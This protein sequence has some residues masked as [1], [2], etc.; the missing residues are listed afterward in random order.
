M[1]IMGQSFS[2]LR[3]WWSG[4]KVYALLGVGVA[5]IQLH[6]LGSSPTQA[7][8]LSKHI[9]MRNLVDSRLGLA[10]GD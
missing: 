3:P 2:R 4:I 1:R 6:S 9:Y 8:K 7:K 10:G 5:R